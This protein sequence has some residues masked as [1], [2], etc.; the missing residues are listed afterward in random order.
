M[1]SCNIRF[2]SVNESRYIVL[3]GSSNLITGTSSRLRVKHDAEM[4]H[5][6]TSGSKRKRKLGKRCK[7][8]EKMGFRK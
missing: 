1:L 4:H 7:S 3:C 8:N 2:A 6:Q 5:D